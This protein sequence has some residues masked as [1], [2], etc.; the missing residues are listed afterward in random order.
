MLWTRSQLGR[1]LFW[2][3][4]KSASKLGAVL[5]LFPSLV[6]SRPSNMALL[7]RKRSS[8]IL[9]LPPRY[10]GTWRECSR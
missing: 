10:S 1:N 7:A 8:L 2:V 6:H 5:L 9:R 4:S 3:L